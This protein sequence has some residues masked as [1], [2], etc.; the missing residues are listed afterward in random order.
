MHAGFLANEENSIW[1]PVQKLEW[2]MFE[3]NLEVEYISILIHKFESLRVKINKLKEKDNVSAREIASI[4][5]KLF[6]LSLH[7]GLFVK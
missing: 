4:V 3:W 5:G 2:L 7:L 1:N 6:Y